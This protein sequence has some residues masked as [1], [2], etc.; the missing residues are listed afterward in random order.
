[1]AATEACRELDQFAYIA[2]HDLKAPLHG[3][4]NPAQWLHWHI[5]RVEFSGSAVEV[6]LGGAQYIELNDN[7][8]SGAGAIGV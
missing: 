5:L 6:R 1:M 3:I 4:V 7:H 8:I 2:S